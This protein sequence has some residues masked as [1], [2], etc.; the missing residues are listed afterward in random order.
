MLAGF[1]ALLLLTG[2][3]GLAHT[4]EAGTTL[5][6]NLGAERFDLSPFLAIAGPDPGGLSIYHVASA[7]FARRFRSAG[8][9]TL[10]LKPSANPYFDLTPGF[11]S[12]QLG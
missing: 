5:Q 8:K 1:A 7:A 10:H 6:L 3:P 11:C 4:G 9:G 12:S 2:R